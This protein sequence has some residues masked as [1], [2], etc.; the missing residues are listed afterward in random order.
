MS[1]QVKFRRGTRTQHNTFTGADGEMTIDTTNDRMVVHDGSKVGGFPHVNFLD[2]INNVFKA[3]A[4][5]LSAGVYTMTLDT[6]PSAYVSLMEVIML[7]GSSNAGAVDININ[8]LGAKDIKKI[9]GTGSV[10]EL[11]AN[12]IRSGVPV[13]LIYDGTRFLAQL[14]GSSGGQM[15]MKILTASGTFTTSA[16]ITSNTKFKFTLIGGGGG[17]AGND[18]GTCGGGGGGAGATAI[19]NVSGLA[20]STGY[21]YTIGA[22]GVAGAAGAAGAAGGNTTLIIG[23][24][25]VTAAGGTGG[26]KAIS[27]PYIAI[28]GTGGTGTNGTINIIGGDGLPGQY[29]SGTSRCGGNGGSSSQ[30]GGGRGALNRNGTI[31]APNTGRAYGSGGGGGVGA[32]VDSTGG[33]DGKIGVIIAEWLE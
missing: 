6:A 5:S 2:N 20:P 13:K 8:A 29:V 26:S 21:T 15:Q 23:A 25:T 28:G 1:T 31:T 22:A 19:Y 4:G 3:A 17:G 18:E 30:G 10:V 27:S 16:N 32:G 11:A 33:A 9:D 7:P 24:T 12:D 14:S